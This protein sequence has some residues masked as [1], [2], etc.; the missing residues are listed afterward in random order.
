LRLELLLT[1]RVPELLYV[2]MK[3]QSTCRSSY[4][5][6]NDCAVH[7]DAAMVELEILFSSS[8]H[9]GPW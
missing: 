7:G 5:K 8:K 6:K 9:I 2:L 3:W 4:K 1:S